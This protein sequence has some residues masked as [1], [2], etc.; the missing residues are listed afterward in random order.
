MQL[1]LAHVRTKLALEN[2]ELL[3]IFIFDGALTRRRV[4]PSKKS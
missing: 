3:P 1:Q 2:K 4:A